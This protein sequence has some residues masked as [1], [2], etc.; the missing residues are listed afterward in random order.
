MNKQRI[1]LVTEPRLI[2]EAVKRAITK[3]PGLEI[4]AEVG[5]LE[6]LQAAFQ[7]TPADWVILFAL[8]G[9]ETPEPVARLLGAYPS[10]RFLAI[11]SDGSRV[12]LEWVEFHAQALDHLTLTGLVA[13][14][15]NDFPREITGDYLDLNMGVQ[16]LD[17]VHGAANTG[18]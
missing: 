8:P 2:Q 6:D 13:V 17:D 18:C 10:V 3:T 11:A 9:Q 14:L 5:C 12:R 4:V 15:N 1:I 16:L 7:S